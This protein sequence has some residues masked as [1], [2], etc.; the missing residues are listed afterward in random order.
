[1]QNKVHFG[2]KAFLKCLMAMMLALC[3]AA[4]TGC[5]GGGNGSYFPHPFDGTKENYSFR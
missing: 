4:Y 3:L 5:G 1:M 2:L